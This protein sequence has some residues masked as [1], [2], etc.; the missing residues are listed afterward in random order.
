L[1]HEAVQVVE[2]ID[3]ASEAYTRVADQTAA[4]A[5]GAGNSVGT[6]RGAEPSGEF[7]LPP[8]VSVTGDGAEV[9][10]AQLE[11]MRNVISGLIDRAGAFDGELSDYEAEL[12]RLAAEERA[13][14]AEMALKRR[15]L[16][17]ARFA[18]D[19]Y[20]RHCGGRQIREIE[21]ALA[22]GEPDTAAPDL[23]LGDPADQPHPLDDN[24]YWNDLLAGDVH[25]D[26]FDYGDIGDTPSVMG[27]ITVP[28]PDDGWDTDG[29]DGRD[30]SSLGVSADPN[31]IKEYQDAYDEVTSDPGYAGDPEPGTVAGGS[32]W[33]P[34]TPE[35][36]AGLPGD[37]VPV[38]PGDDKGEPD[39]G[40]ED[41][42][43]PGDPGPAPTP[44]PQGDPTPDEALTAEDDGEAG[45]PGLPGPVTS[46]GALPSLAPVIAEFP[47]IAMPEA[48]AASIKD[49]AALQERINRLGITPA[50]AGLQIEPCGWDANT[51]C[52]RLAGPASFD[53]QACVA[54]VTAA[55]TQCKAYPALRSQPSLQS[56]LTACDIFATEARTGLD[57][58]GYARD[59]VASLNSPLELRLAQLRAD[60]A[61]L[62]VLERELRDAVEDRRVHVYAHA[63]T[64]EVTIHDGPYF[65]P[66]PPILYTGTSRYPASPRQV[67]TMDGLQQRKAEVLDEIAQLEARVA[68]TRDLEWRT[69]ALDFWNRVAGFGSDQNCKSA[70]AI[71]QGQAECRAFCQAQAV[72]GAGPPQPLEF[73]RSLRGPLRALMSADTQRWLIPPSARQAP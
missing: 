59:K 46:P 38:L 6:A 44:D 64:G 48:N 63:D 72:P 69:S 14:E 61:R 8:L 42:G 18:L 22:L 12:V 68:A 9:A 39:E 53:V 23:D 56:C 28:Y 3:A 27:E 30:Q 43:L 24:D 50:S 4:E 10:N 25:L 21:D 36:D 41:A 55:V 20:A 33:V 65:E 67:A 57:L 1:F 51:I 2:G 11:G 37:A 31:M 71:T 19:L 7:T 62:R 58:H 60:L 45:L 17:T 26:D 54:T 66:T 35:D 29:A 5:R 47:E 13:L 70:A 34:I 52:N 40:T 16:Q 32:R 49:L 73:C 15:A